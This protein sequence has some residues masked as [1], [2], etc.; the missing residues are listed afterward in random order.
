MAGPGEDGITGFALFRIWISV[1][2]QEK[3]AQAR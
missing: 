1:Q 3:T 2:G